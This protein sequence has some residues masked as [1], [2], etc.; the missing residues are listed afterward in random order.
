M[1]RQTYLIAALLL[2]AV[3]VLIALF[4]RDGL[5]RPYVGDVLA[6]AL[7][8]AGVRGFTPLGLVP[9]LAAALAIAA[10]VE[11]AQAL[12]LLDA[13]GLGGNVVARTV[14][15]G[16]FDWADLAAYCAGAAIIVLVEQVRS[17][18]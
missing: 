8:Y 3:E 18:H 11:V 9:A 6:V 16:V 7:V 4:V 1:T 13:I 2:F 12:H 5:V 17:R 14:L 15:G 10:A